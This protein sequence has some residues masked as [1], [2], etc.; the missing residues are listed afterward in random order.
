M[1]YPHR[2]K[3]KIEETLSTSEFERLLE[4]A[5][6][7]TEARRKQMEGQP[8]F[9]DVDVVAFLA[10]LYYTGLRVTEVIG[11]PPHKYKVKDGTV[12]SS[13]TVEGIRKENVRIMDTLLR[14]E[15]YEVRKH[16]RRYGPLWIPLNKVGVSE[17]IET[18]KNTKEGHRLF[19]ISR[20]Q[21]WR[22]VQEVTG[23]LYPH[24][25]RMNRATRFAEH[26]DTSIKD[27]QDWFGWRE[28]ISPSKYMAKG[29]RK[30]KKMAERL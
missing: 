17:I 9:K 8:R 22:F 6:E 14:V 15:A 27:L 10:F 16:G 11:D 24:Y 2:Y 23:K 30:M 1:H 4:Q 21:A 13:E 5:K 18:W 20:T 7:Y 12:K 19:P 3:K 28:L 25:F 26:P 29:G